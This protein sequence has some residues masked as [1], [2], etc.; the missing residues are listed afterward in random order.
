VSV[1]LE[2]RK[3]SSWNVKYIQSLILNE[4]QISEKNL[5]L[6]VQNKCSKKYKKEKTL[7]NKM[8]DYPE[9]SLI[10]NVCYKY[11]CKAGVSERAS[12]CF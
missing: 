4:I 8:H 12:K 11:R 10:C 2:F 3:I 6:F 1:N 9:H 7:R 5:R